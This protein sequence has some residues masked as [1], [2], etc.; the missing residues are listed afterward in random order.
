M[1]SLVRLGSP[2]YLYH[3]QFGGEHYFQVDGGMARAFGESSNVH[4]LYKKSLSGANGHRLSN[5]FTVG[6]AHAF[7]MP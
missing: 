3:D 1:N 2:Y 7:A 4:F 5:G 6:L